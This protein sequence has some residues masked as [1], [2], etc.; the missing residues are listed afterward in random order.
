MAL[1]VFCLSSEPTSRPKGHEVGCCL[2]LKSISREWARLVMPQRDGAYRDRTR[3]PP[4]P[5]SG[6]PAE[7]CERCQVVLSRPGC[8]LT[9]SSGHLSVCRICY[10]LGDL[11][12][13]CVCL[14]L[15][16]CVCVCI[17]LWSEG[18]A[19]RRDRD[20]IHLSGSR[21]A[22]MRAPSGTTPDVCT[23]C[24]VLLWPDAPPPLSPRSRGASEA[25][26]LTPPVPAGGLFHVCV[27]VCVCVFRWVGGRLV[28][29]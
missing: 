23:R 24:W 27:C 11:A 6:A 21:A 19:Q 29:S 17:V 10:F 9:T 20:M 5:A 13:L 14:C 1:A 4:R 3:S 7:V 18:E 16:V 2:I 28:E 22:S 25:S 8:S 15:C 12:N 26:P